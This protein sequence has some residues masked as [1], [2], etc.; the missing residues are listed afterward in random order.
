MLN[1][2]LLQD[3]RLVPNVQ[4]VHI[5]LVLNELMY[6]NNFFM[7]VLIISIYIANIPKSFKIEN[8]F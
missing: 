2:Q 8:L 4:D 7:I 5:E 1:E 3:K 6:V